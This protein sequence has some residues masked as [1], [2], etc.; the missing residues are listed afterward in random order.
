MTDKVIKIFV[1]IA[2]SISNIVIIYFIAHIFN[3]TATNELISCVI[4]YVTW[5]VVRSW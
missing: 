5:L 2:L 1:T 3:T 4:T